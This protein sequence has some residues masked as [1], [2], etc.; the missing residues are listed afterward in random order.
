MELARVKREF[1]EMKM[2]RDLLKNNGLL[3]EGVA[4]KYGRMEELR[5]HYP[6]AVMCRV[7]EVSESSYYAWRDR[8][9][10]P[11]AKESDRLEV[12]IRAAHQRTRKTC[13][14]ER[15]QRDLADN[16]IQARVFRIKRLRKKLDIRCKQKRKFKVTTDTKTQPACRT[17]CAGTKLCGQPPQPGVGK[18][19]HLSSN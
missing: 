14:P 16:G 10:L 19:Y 3:R 4:V 12:E 1:V 8:P 11:R 18:R 6:V 2:K 17:E 13:G 7:Y 5:P 15:L 9:L